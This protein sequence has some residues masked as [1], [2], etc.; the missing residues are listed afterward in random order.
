M[1][2][3][4]TRWRWPSGGW[5]SRTTLLGISSRLWRNC[6]G[7]WIQR[8]A[9][10]NI[11][12]GKDDFAGAEQ[13]ILKAAGQAP[14][15][16]EAAV[17]VGRFYLLA[18][19]PGEAE[20]QVRRALS[21]DSRNGAALLALGETQMAKGDRQQAERTFAQLSS[22]GDKTY[23]AVHASFLVQEKRYDEAIPELQQLAFKDPGNAELRSYLVAAYM[24]A[25]KLAEAEK[26]LK[27]ALVQNKRDLD[28]SLQY[29][30]FLLRSKRVREAETGV[31]TVM[32]FQ[33][34]LAQAH[35]L[36]AAVYEARHETRNQQ[37]ELIQALR[38]SPDQLAARIRLAR[39]LL[40]TGDVNRARDVVE[41]APPPQKRSLDLLVERNWVLMA[42]R[43]LP[44]LRTQLD[45]GLGVSR[46]PELLLQDGLLKEQLKQ[47]E[48]AGAALRESLQ[49]TPE[50]VRT[51]STLARVYV[52]QKKN[53]AAEGMI[54]D[55][56]ARYP[57]SAQIQ[58]FVGGWMAATGRF[59]QAREGFLR[60]K[61]AEP[62]YAGADLTLGRVAGMQKK[63][64]EARRILLP[65]CTGETAAAAHM[66]LANVDEESGATASAIQHYRKAIAEDAGNAVAYNNLAFLLAKDPKRLDEALSYAKAAVPLGAT[67]SLHDTL[68]WIHYQK[69]IYGAAVRYLDE[70][71]AGEGNAVQRYHL[72]M[73]CFK[74]GEVARGQ[75]VLK[76]ALGMDPNLPEAR[77]AL[78][79]QAASLAKTSP[80][81]DA[82][83]P[84][85]GMPH[86]NR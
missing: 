58:M 55:Y 17:A 12:L 67:P 46:T 20:K 31:A 84:S 10:A 44:E 6:P 80:R 8:F 11:Q 29:A 85:A 78:A 51:I 34:D 22:L 57:K 15:S 28:V 16:V 82:V 64:D 74:L 37:G 75:S 42:Q 40:M 1:P 24:G 19:K 53:A 2:P 72:A 52:E 41:Q 30:E 23:K 59:D 7:T 71:V 63:W 26:L 61:A 13:T 70:A 76:V 50:D 68:G 86:S 38:I 9:L 25:N 36:M 69:G 27:A 43:Q 81:K 39:S 5:A 45:A 54:A 33:S 79:V 56:S 35:V 47:Y 32:R 73:A 48:A 83:R 4:G 49:Q 65:L 18:G 66:L 21:L 77:M 62:G 60:A 3:G 14:K